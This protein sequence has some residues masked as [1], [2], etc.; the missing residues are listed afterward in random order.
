MK[1]NRA[2]A[3]MLILAVLVRLFVPANAVAHPVTTDGTIGDWFA[4]SP[5]TSPGAYP[6]PNTGQVARNATQ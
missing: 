6:N 2:T 4:T 3:L 5:I 1:R